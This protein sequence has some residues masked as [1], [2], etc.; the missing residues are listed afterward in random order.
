[1]AVGETQAP[2]CKRLKTSVFYKFEDNDHALVVPVD[3][4]VTYMSLR[5]PPE[6]PKS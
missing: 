6:T 5:V 4:L 3:E 2:D 1:M